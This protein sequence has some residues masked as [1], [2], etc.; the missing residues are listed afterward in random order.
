MSG[1]FGDS[2][3]E[4]SIGQFETSEMNGSSAKLT[5]LGMEKKQGGERGELQ[6]LRRAI[7]TI[8]L[9]E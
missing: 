2:G 8:Y 9:N 5:E 1:T 4:G 7:F 6:F 3:W